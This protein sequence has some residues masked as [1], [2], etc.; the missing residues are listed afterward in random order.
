V[1]QGEE[2]GTPV[3][4]VLRRQAEDLRQDRRERAQSAAQRAPVLMTIP[5]VVCFMPAMAAVVIVPSI[6]NLV[7][8]TNSIGGG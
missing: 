3:A 8:F 2:L 4:D 6:L 1:S 7:R 5:L